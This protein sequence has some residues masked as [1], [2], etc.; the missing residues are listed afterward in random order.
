[1]NNDLSN[2]DIRSFDDSLQ[3]LYVYFF[4]QH[5]FRIDDLFNPKKIWNALSLWKKFAEGVGLVPKIVQT[6]NLLMSVSHAAFYC[7]RKMEI[8]R[9]EGGVTTMDHHLFH[10][11]VEENEM[12]IVDEDEN[13]YDSIEE[14][15]NRLKRKCRVSGFTF[16]KLALLVI[17][18][19]VAESK[20][21]VKKF[22]KTKIIGSLSGISNFSI[23]GYGG[24]G[25][26]EK[27]FVDFIEDNFLIKF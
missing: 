7:F 15:M 26:I 23:D 22:G 6:K 20:A 27:Q 2:F 10:D 21:W 9:S 17:M 11:Q 14:E 1:M 12:D 25:S 8:M 3:P 18:K 4:K 13:S 24:A 5:Q 16:F 19:R